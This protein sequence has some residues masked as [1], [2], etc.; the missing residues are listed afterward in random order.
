MLGNIELK[1]SGLGREVGA[2]LRF[3]VILVVEF[4]NLLGVLSVSLS[5][6]V[7]LILEVLLLSEELCVEVL[8]LVQVALQPGNFDVPVVEAVLLAI[9]L[10]VEIG[11]LLFSIDEEVLLVINLLS[12]GLD[13]IDVNF[14]S[15]S[16]IL[17]HS[18]L[19]IGYPV[20]VLLEREQL[21]LEVLILPL[22]SSQVHGLLTELGHKSVLVVLH[23]TLVDQL[24]LGASWHI[25]K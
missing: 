10:G 20:E 18:S 24:S 21:V 7:E 13:H 25:F 5:Q 8:V 14:Y 16:I 3:Q 23:L 2:L 6:I 4:V 11:V 17:F 22:S 1:L 9:E 19:V 15:A 12:Q